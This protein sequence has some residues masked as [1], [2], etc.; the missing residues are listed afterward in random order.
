MYQE[1]GTHHASSNAQNAPKRGHKSI[2][3]PIVRQMFQTHSNTLRAIGG[4]PT[5]LGQNMSIMT[6]TS[7]ILIFEDKNEEKCSDRSTIT[8]SRLH[9]QTRSPHLMH[10]RVRAPNSK[11]LYHNHSGRAP[12]TP[13]TAT[14]GIAD[15]GTCVARANA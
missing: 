5:E 3:A 1:S 13:F 8:Y 7:S 6:Q 10:H 14:P 4:Y 2:A 12:T 11:L 9:P 15:V